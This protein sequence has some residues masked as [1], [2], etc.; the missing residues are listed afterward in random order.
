MKT[1][2]QYDFKFASGAP[3]SQILEL[4][5]LALIGRKENVVLLGPSGVRKAHLASALAHRAI[6]AGFDSIHISGRP[7]LAT[8]RGPS[9]GRLVQYFSR[10]VQRAKLVVIHEIG[11]LPFGRD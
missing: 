3:Q 2:E 1:V 8:R 9:S 10:V 11:Y 4:A 5:G 6:M 7:Y